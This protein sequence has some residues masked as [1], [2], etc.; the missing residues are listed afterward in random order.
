MARTDPNIYA[1]L[2]NCGLLPPVGVVLADGTINAQLYLKNGV[3]LDNNAAYPNIAYI[4]RA[5]TFTATPQTA[6]TFNGST[7]LQ[8]AGTDINTN[9]ALSNVAYLDRT[10]QTLAGHLNLASGK[11]FKLNGTDLNT[12]TAL[13]NVAYLDRANTFTASP[14]TAPTIN[15]ST[16]L[17]VAGV[18][19]NT[20]TALSNVA[21]LDKANT[22]TGTPQTA[23][24]INAS[25][26]LQVGGASINTAGTLSNVAYLSQDQTFAGNLTLSGQARIKLYKSGGYS[27]GFL[28]NNTVVTLTWDALEIDVGGMNGSGIATVVKAGTYL[29]I[30]NLGWTTGSDNATGTR[31]LRLLKNTTIVGL[32]ERT[33]VNGVNTR[34]HC[35]TIVVCAVNDTLSM[36]GFQTSGGNMTPENGATRTWLAIARL[37]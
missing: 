2:I 24:T 18:N 29:M 22:F 7:A 5:N 25:T 14:Q 21:Y 26:A 12:N 27:A 23:P 9:T 31:Q 6:P 10:T 1:R 13:P 3:A 8:Y 32:D 30:G 33:P 35:S 16:A 37:F 19:I 11:A 28:T 4:N 17:Q 15:G 20:N 34:S 36:A